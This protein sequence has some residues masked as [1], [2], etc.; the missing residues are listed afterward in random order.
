[1]GSANGQLVIVLAVVAVAAL[2]LLRAAWQ[3]WSGKK[4][5]CGSGCGKCSTPATTEGPGTN[6]RIPLN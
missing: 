4:S 5:A 3:T 2:Y 1:M 6:R